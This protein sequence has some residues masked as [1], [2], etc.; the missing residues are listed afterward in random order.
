MDFQFPN[1]LGDKLVPS[2]NG[3]QVCVEL[4][5]MQHIV[6]KFRNVITQ[7][8]DTMI[9]GLESVRVANNL[10]FELRSGRSVGKHVT[11]PLSFLHLM[12]NFFLVR[13]L[14]PKYNSRLINQ[15]LK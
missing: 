9:Y 6:K 15:F 10:K 11:I 8:H 2:D 13:I 1:Q 14:F 7:K 4:N 3:R 5:L 12:K